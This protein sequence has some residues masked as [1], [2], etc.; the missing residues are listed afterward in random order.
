MSDM[1]NVSLIMEKELINSAW[2]K[3]LAI[4]NPQDLQYAYEAIEDQLDALSREWSEDNV[5]DVELN[6]Y[7][8]GLCEVKNKISQILNNPQNKTY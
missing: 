2:S 7:I 3:Q 1:D 6:T 4:L 5:K 8:D